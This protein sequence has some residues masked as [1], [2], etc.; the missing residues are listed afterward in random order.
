M[1]SL[2]TVAIAA[3]LGTGLACYAFLRR[4]SYNIL[5][6]LIVISI[7][8]PFSASLLVVLCATNLVPWSKFVLF[9][10][11]LLAYLVGARISAW[12]FPRSSFRKHIRF[13]TEDFTRSEIT[14]LLVSAVAM[15][16]V[17]AILGLIVG[18]AGDARQQFGK[19]FRPLM[20]IQNGLFL[21]SLILLLSPKLSTS[22][23]VKRILALSILSIPFSGKSVFVPVLYWLGLR[24]YMHVRRVTART[25]ALSALAVVSGVTIMAL[26]AY[27]K[28]S[29]AGVFFLIGYRLWMS[30]DVYIWAYQLHGLSALRGHYNVDFIPYILH[31]LTALVGIHSY[32]K[33]LGAMLASEVTGENL[34][35]G[36]NPQ[37]PVLLDYFFPAS[38]VV[39]SLIAFLFG[40]LVIG[41]RRLGLILSAFR[42]RF[43]RLGAIAAAIFCPAA[44][45]IAEE[46]VLITLVGILAVTI[47]GVLLDLVHRRTASPGLSN[48]PATPA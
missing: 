9:V 21:I 47:A 41:I 6:P 15:T 16:L 33:P 30:G 20:L 14:A 11:V 35:T 19:T 24:L 44:G 46:Q 23:A 32:T 37:L 17:L 31:P 12:N 43:V 4:I 27:G 29:V 40:F 18:A 2:V 36:P 13:A 25:I 22:R 38:P 34:L 28:S 39:A 5:D 45:F 7:F 3:W 8:L 1:T 10:S 26:L 42:S 48:S